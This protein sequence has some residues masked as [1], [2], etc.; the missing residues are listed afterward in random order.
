M[1][2]AFWGSVLATVVGQ[3]IVLII[4]GVWN[5]RLTGRDFELAL[6]WVVGGG[7]AAWGL[8]R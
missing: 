4:K 3:L 2:D 6:Y 1:T 8:T 7:V 5:G